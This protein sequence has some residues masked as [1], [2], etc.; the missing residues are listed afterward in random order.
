MMKIKKITAVIFAAS[1]V[2][3]FP[4]Q[5]NM[6]NALNSMFAANVTIPGAYQSATRSGFVG[7]GI[8]LRTPIKPINL[9]AFDPP[10]ISAGCGGLDMYGGSFS[11][12][13]SAQFTALLRNI[14]NN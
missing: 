6:Q 8:T 13:N 14:M 10:R 9:F 7:G 11:F 3:S 1:F 5:A 12:I 2:I 4:A